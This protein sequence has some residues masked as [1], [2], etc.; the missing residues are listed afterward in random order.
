MLQTRRLGYFDNLEKFQKTDNPQNCFSFFRCKKGYFDK[1]QHKMHTKSHNW[2]RIFFMLENMY[3]CSNKTTPLPQEVVARRG[4]PL[5][6]NRKSAPGF[7]LPFELLKFGTFGN[8]PQ[9]LSTKSF[10]RDALLQLSSTQWL[11]GWPSSKTK[12]AQKR[13][14]ILAEPHF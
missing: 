2:Y 9:F 6:C 4:Q 3:S 8:L 7:F 1:F 10:Q 13:K 11:K 14:G 5:W 12:S